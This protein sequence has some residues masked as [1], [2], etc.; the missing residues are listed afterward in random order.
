MHSVGIRPRVHI[1]QVVRN[2]TVF[3]FKN[4]QGKPLNTDS[5]LQTV[6]RLFALLHER[7]VEYLLVGGVA[8]LQYIEG[9][10][11]EDIDLIMALP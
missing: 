6:S 1:G 5:L 7:Q 4:W 11:T 9:R 3:N 8:L 10:N 2:A